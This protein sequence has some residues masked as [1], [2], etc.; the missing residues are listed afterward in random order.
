MKTNCR[1]KHYALPKP[2]KHGFS[3]A[4]G[5]LILQACERK[6]TMLI[7]INRYFSEIQAFYG[8]SIYF[9]T[10]TRSLRFRNLKR[11]PLGQGWRTNGTRAQNARRKHFLGMR[12]SLLSHFF[13]KFILLYQRLYI[14]KHMCAYTHILLLRGCIWITVVPNNTTNGTFLLKSEAVQSVGYLS[15]GCRPGCDWANTWHW[16]QFLK[17]SFQIGSSSSTSTSIFYS[18]SHSLTRSLLEL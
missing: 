6:W 8:I 4:S 7:H 12:H 13:F 5:E 2:A 1:Y 17:S 9:I 16:K 11:G 18:L 15:L 3:V 14:V 10:K